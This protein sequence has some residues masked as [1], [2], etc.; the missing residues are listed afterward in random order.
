MRNP[1]ALSM[2]L[3]AAAMLGGCGGGGAGGS[4]G[5]GNIQPGS[6]PPPA[7]FTRFL[8]VGTEENT[9]A[10][11]LAQT[12]SGASPDG[13]FVTSR[14]VNAIETGRMQLFFDAQFQPTVVAIETARSAPIWSGTGQ[15]AC[16]IELCLTGNQ[17]A[18][19]AVANA[20][21]GL[22][23]DYQTFG[24]WVDAPTLT[25]REIGAM[26]V[27]APTPAAALPASGT[28][29]YDGVSAGVYVDPAGQIF[30]HVATLSATADFGVARSLTLS[31][32]GTTLLSAGGRATSVPDLNLNGTLSW[33]A[34]SS[35]FAGALSTSAQDLTGTATG[36]F[37]GPAA[38]E[39]GGIFTL[40]PGG[41]SSETFS[42]AFGGIARR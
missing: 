7:P 16:G 24:Y 22:G 13:T 8:D 30:E 15:I 36:R 26:T 19:G 14:S 20:V 18:F 39:I 38:E 10:A 28:A 42:G 29:V 2:T 6:P 40:A 1:L 3:F 37:Y 33:A 23:W 35:Q 21:A 11:G 12:V 41:A 27:G 9:E 32:S 17:Q 25:T 31:T 34:G 5:V 4:V